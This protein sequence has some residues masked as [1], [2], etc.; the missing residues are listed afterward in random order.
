[1]ALRRRRRPRPPARIVTTEVVAQARLGFDY[2]LKQSNRRT[3][4][5]LQV[6]AGRVEVAAPA[7]L[8]AAEAHRF[9]AA[10]QQWVLAQL[11][12]Q[13]Q[14]LEETADYRF[15]D[16][17]AFPYLGRN[18]RLRVKKAGQTSVQLLE[19]PVFERVCVEGASVEDAG[20]DE[21]GVIEVRLGSRSRKLERDQI[22][23]ALKQW[24]RRQAEE[25][26]SDKTYAAA[27][28]LGVTVKAIN[29][30]QTKSKWGHCTA[31]GVIQYNWWI[32]Q[33]PEPVLDY[34]VAH[35][36]S[37]RVHLN[38]S[39]RFWQ[40]VAVLCP[41]YQRLRRWLRDNGHRFGL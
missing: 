13:R 7:A 19:T 3:T 16:G 6:K 8:A 5:A 26:L 37:H 41:D 2:L 22:Q 18:Y 14:R 40:Q 31:G 30:R 12:R 17:E 20:V 33:A 9:V 23:Q 38:H 11:D 39:P 25:L 1:M 21:P 34:L 29:F 36:V 15:E 27:R 24:Y 4:L 32:V 10:K 28:Q 35:E